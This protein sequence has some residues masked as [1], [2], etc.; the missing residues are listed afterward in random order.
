MVLALIRMPHEVPLLRAME[1]VLLRIKPLLLETKRQE[2]L[3]LALQEELLEAR[4]TFVES[5]SS[6]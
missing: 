6:R 2:A 1:T 3:R 5:A 4:D